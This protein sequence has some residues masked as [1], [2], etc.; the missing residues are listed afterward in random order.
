MKEWTYLEDGWPGMSRLRGRGGGCG[1]G[2]RRRRR[3]HV[4]RRQR[5]R[6]GLKSWPHRRRHRHSKVSALTPR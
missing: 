3:R 4:V 1:G 5:L 2:G 6:D